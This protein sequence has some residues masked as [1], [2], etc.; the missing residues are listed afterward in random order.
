M[1]LSN[2][3]DKVTRK[4]GQVWGQADRA[5][6][7]WLPGGDASP[8]SPIRKR[9]S[10]VPKAAAA[11]GFNQLPDRVN[12]FG[13]YM[14]GVGNRN[15]QLDPSTLADLRESTR[16]EEVYKQEIPSQFGGGVMVQPKAGPYLPQSGAVNPYYT[17]P[18]S[19]TNT[20]G[21]FT[22]V[23][24]PGANKLDFIDTYDMIN[25]A[26]DPDLVSGKTQPVKAWNEVEAIWNPA[27]MYRNKKPSIPSGVTFNPPSEA[28]TPENVNRGLRV[29]GENT[30]FSPATRFA[31]AL[32]YLSPVKPEPY[33]VNITVPYTG[34]I[35]R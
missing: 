5:L 21:R 4:A 34:E 22:A 27:A 35:S 2:F 30:T 25:T 8:L 28:Y 9:A 13:R 18:K 20:L 32:M 29:T 33:D 11:V 17:Q 26:E 23:A 14:T 6:G 12:L 7:G 3:F 15:L 24:D 1:P 31:R 16:K 19:V 10:E